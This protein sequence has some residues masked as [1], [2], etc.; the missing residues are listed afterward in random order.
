MIE[1]VN[2]VAAASGGVWGL[3]KVSESERKLIAE[4]EAALEE[5]R[6][7]VTADSAWTHRTLSQFRQTPY[8]F[9]RSN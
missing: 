2:R 3:R 9:S 8:D 4:V 7:R 5:A 6:R 1:S